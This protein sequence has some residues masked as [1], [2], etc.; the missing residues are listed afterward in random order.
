MLFPAIAR[1]HYPAYTLVNGTA[2]RAVEDAA[3]AVR[4]GKMQG[5]HP[6]VDLAASSHAL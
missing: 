1:R 6:V 2:P 5:P 3:G 4:A